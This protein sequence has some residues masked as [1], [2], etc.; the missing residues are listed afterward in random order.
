MSAPQ[1]PN[2]PQ[3][4]RRTR[5]ELLE[6]E[7]KLRA[8]VDAVAAKRRTLPLGGRLGD[9]YVFEQSDD[10][11]TV[12]TVPFEQLFGDHATLILY[13]MMFGREWDAPCPSCTSLVDAFNANYHPVSQHSAM[14]VVGAASADQFDA[15]ARQRHWRIPVY[16]AGE[17]SY[18]LDYMPRDDV[19]DPALVS[20][21]NVFRKTDDGIFHFW[22]SELVAHPKDNGHPSHVDSVWPFWNLLDMTPDGRGDICV[23]PQDYEHEYFTRKVF[24]GN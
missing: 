2:E 9:D 18:L 4:Y 3:D 7:K 5:D 15:L 20:M 22:G 23:P 11:G 19:S 8:Q 14:A 17:S 12:R 1:F 6:M 16:S 10:S 13:S 24:P 21:M